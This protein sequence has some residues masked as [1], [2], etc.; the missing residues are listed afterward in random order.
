MT[1]SVASFAARIVGTEKT[2]IAD[3][4]NDRFLLSLRQLPKKGI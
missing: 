3:D 1:R 2:E 4:R